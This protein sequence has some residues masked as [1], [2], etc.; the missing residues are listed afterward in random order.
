VTTSRTG[1][2]ARITG[3]VRPSIKKALKAAARKNRVSESVILD[4]VLE[5]LL[6]KKEEGK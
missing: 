3:Y 1:R 5:A 4:T 2:T 6:P